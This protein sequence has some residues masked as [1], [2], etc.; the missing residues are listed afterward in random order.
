MWEHRRS[1]I[2]GELIAKELEA[3]QAG[4]HS[5]DGQL[6][7][8]RWTEEGDQQHFRVSGVWQQVFCRQ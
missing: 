1:E 4:E 8:A 3:G 6:A 2:D 5:G 7:N